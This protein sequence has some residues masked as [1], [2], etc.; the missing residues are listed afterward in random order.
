MDKHIKTD[1][2]PR[3]ISNAEYIRQM[4]NE[5][6]KDF[7]ERLEYRDEKPWD[8]EF[9]SQYCDTCKTEACSLSG[10]C[11]VGVKDV[12]AWWLE[13]PNKSNL[14]LVDREQINRDFLV[15]EHKICSLCVHEKTCNDQQ[16]HQCEF[17]CTLFDYKGFHPFRQ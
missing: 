12:I 10:V 1:T 8:I 14:Y 6:L 15:A 2:A 3:R 13:Q 11:P 5:Q 9:S 7:I 16:A 17:D 4:N